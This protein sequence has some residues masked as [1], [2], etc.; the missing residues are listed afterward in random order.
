MQSWSSQQ[1]LCL[2]GPT[3]PHEQSIAVKAS[4]VCQCLQCR[5]SITGQHAC[6]KEVSSVRDEVGQRQHSRH[7]QL[8]IRKNPLQMS[9]QALPSVSGALA[10]PGKTAASAEYFTSQ[11]TESWH[12]WQPHPQDGAK[13]ASG[14]LEVSTYDDS[15]GA[16][17]LTRP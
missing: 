16:M 7:E 10:L 8:S 11:S 15:L 13:P 12:H 5:D 1:A 4:E 3:G 6:L 2:C 14:V 17:G 9:D